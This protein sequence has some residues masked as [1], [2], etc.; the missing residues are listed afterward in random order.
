M[1]SAILP[2]PLRRWALP[3]ALALSSAVFTGCASGSLSYSPTEVAVNSPA[4]KLVGPLE[5][6][7]IVKE[8]VDEHPGTGYMVG[9]GDSMLP[10]YRDHTVVI[11]E[12]VPLS[13][14]KAGMTAVFLGDSGFP[15][16]HVLVKKTR[17]GW[18]ARG[19]NNPRCDARRVREDNYIAAVI[20]AYEPTGSPLLALLPKPTGLP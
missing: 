15:V 18:M 9:S 10:L 20:E 17:E 13:Q 16:A 8:Y 14:L 7:R 3:A 2:A 1:N 19:L 12:R 6:Y 4:A 5:L 11:T